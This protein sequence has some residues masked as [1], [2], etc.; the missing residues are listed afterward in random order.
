[1]KAGII[2]M[3]EFTWELS[4]KTLKEYIQDQNIEFLPSPR[5]TIKE[6]YQLRKIS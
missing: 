4:W 2:K 3:Y 6:A 1:M 5:Q